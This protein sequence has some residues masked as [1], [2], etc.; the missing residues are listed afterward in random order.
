MSNSHL[1]VLALTK[2]SDQLEGYGSS[3][4]GGHRKAIQ[5]LLQALEDGLR[6]TLGPHYHL[7]SIDPGVGKSLSVSKFLKAWKGEGFKPNSS[8]LI[9]LSRLQEINEFLEHSGLTKD[10]VAVLTSSK[11]HN[12]L[13]VSREIHGSARVMF[14]TQQMIEKRTRGVDFADAAEFH[15]KGKA[16][17][18]R[19]WD[20]SY[21]PAQ[22]LTLKVDDLARLP[23]A[24]RRQFP[25]YIA[26]LQGLVTRLWAAADQEQVTVPRELGE[27][28][29]AARSLKDR[30]LAEVIEGLGRLSG[31]AVTVVDR[32]KG[33]IRLAGS[34]P[35]IPY[36]FAP[37]VILDASGRT[38]STYDVWEHSGAP[39]LRL[40]PA[41]K[42]YRNLHVN[43]WERSVGKGAFQKAATREEI[44]EAVAAAIR[45]KTSSSWL[46][47]TYKD[48]PIEDAIRRAL[49]NEPADELHFLTWGNHHGTN[50][51]SECENV[52]LIGQLTYSSEGYTSLALAAGAQAGIT[53]NE[54]ESLLKAGEYRHNWLQALTRAS[55][56]KTKGELAGSCTAYVIAAPNVSARALIEEAFPGCSIDTWL[57]VLTKVKGQA[58][59]LI[60][61]L[62]E[63]ERSDALPVT[64]RELRQALDIN[65]QNFSRLLAKP[66][67]QSHMDRLGLRN[68]RLDIGKSHGFTPWE[69][70]GFMFDQL[71]EL[72]G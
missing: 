72:V 69:G 1:S 15:F 65:A 7:S 23:A 10:E 63:A 68:S 4:T 43:L 26:E 28:T 33:D 42:N 39:L 55:V 47:V 21:I 70:G 5:A 40:P 67:V 22:H 30:H 46:I 53:P 18:L 60:E 27:P 19:I 52:V 13:G 45:G 25:E 11:E 34:A 17:T 6:G 2:V 29:G 16:R 44:V 64:K 59:R 51:Y 54:A 36:D 37:L 12:S 58:G 61:L 8:V 14:T 66:E 48:H 38:R 62:V 24:L 20:E 9:G 32:G 41:T 3:L 31:S 71:D 57:P 49:K 35:P 50:A 56:R